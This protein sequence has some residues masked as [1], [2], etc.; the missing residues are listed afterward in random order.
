M[1]TREHK[2]HVSR[3]SHLKRWIKHPRGGIGTLMDVSTK[4]CTPCV[5]KMTLDL[6]DYGASVRWT[7]EGTII[8]HVSL[9][10]DTPFTIRLQDNAWIVEEL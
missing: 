1:Q 6:L 4:T 10:G 5:G 7:W 8:G 2:Q 9:N 3:L